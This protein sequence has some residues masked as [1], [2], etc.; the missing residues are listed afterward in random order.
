MVK[1]CT[2]TDMC[3]GWKWVTLTNTLAY[4][5]TEIMVVVKS[6]IANASGWY[7]QQHSFLGNV[8]LT[9]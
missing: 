8:N 7:S 4:C 2:Q 3:L 9:S 6:F 5:G 1:S